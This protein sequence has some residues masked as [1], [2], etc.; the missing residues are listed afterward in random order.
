[1]NKCPY[2]KIYFTPHVKVGSR[3][4]TC[5]DP[6]C[7]KALKAD[8]NKRWRRKNPE[9]YRDNY[10]QLRE[11]LDQHPSYLKHYRQSHPEYVQKN[12]EAQRRRDRSKRLRL[13]IQAQLKR[14]APEI[15]DQLWNSSNLDIQAQLGIKPFEMTFLFSTLPCLDIQVHMDRSFCLLENSTTATGR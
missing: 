3:Q 2:C 13:D 11:W 10:T 9:Y 5:G 8:N 7:K 6:I 15:T 12:R 1:M 14:Q 4:K